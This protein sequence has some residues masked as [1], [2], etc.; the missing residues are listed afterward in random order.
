LQPY[1]RL[2]KTLHILRWYAQP[3]DR[4]RITRQLNK[5]E[6]LHDRRAF[7]MVANNGQLRRKSPT[8]LAH[9]ALCLNLV[10][11]AVIC[12]NTVYMAAALEQLVRA[13][14]PVQERDLAHVW[15]TRDA[16]INVYGKYHFNVEEVWGRHALR[17]LRQPGT[18]VS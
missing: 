3:E 12:W 15:P 5:G 2:I 10:T 17:P 7:L 16:H 13:G 11:N 8:E 18:V 6:A 14:Y 1:G 9:Q 4:R